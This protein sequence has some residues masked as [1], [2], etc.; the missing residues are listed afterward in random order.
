MEHSLTFLDRTGVAGT[1]HHDRAPVQILGDARQRRRGAEPHDRA[2]LVGS[3]A[4]EVAVAAED[5]HGVGRVPDDGP[6][7][8]GGA[9]GVEAELER[10]DHA[11]VAAAASQRP[12]QVGELVLGHPQQLA[13]GRYDVNGEDVVDREAVLAHQPA[14]ATAEGEPGDAGVADD[15][16]GGGQTVRLRLAVD[17]APQRTTLHPDFAVGGI[18]PHG[19]HR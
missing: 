16:S 10:G 3:V 11:E 5:L 7:Q 2:E 8:N 18:D 12:E 13:V 17:V 14:D 9:D 15:S 1:D 4:D 19:S 6:G